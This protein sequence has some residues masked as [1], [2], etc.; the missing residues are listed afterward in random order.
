MAADLYMSA[1]AVSILAIAIGL[2]HGFLNGTALKEGAGTLG[3]LGIMIM[4]FVLV[5]L[6]S[7]IVVSLKKHWTR[8]AVRVAGSWIFASGL[9]MIGWLIREAK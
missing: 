9:L 5:A 4:L 7:A 6:V 1:D 2:L 3:L 8:I